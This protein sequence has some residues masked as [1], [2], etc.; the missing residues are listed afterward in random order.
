MGG[1]LVALL[2]KIMWF[3]S[4]LRIFQALCVNSH[5]QSE[6][7]WKILTFIIKIHRKL[8]PAPKGAGLT[9]FSFDSGFLGCKEIP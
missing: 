8:L 1:M 3:L 4:M 7:G 9:E 2:T 6:T 5:H